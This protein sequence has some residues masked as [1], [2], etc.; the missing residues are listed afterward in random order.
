MTAKALTAKSESNRSN[1]ANNKKEDVYSIKVTE[2]NEKNA[3][4]TKKEGLKKNIDLDRVKN[5][6]DLFG[7]DEEGEGENHSNSNSRGAHSN[8]VAV[9]STPNPS[10]SLYK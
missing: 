4:K 2:T 7:S 1:S 5:F 10:T 9:A 8:S 6:D 3:E